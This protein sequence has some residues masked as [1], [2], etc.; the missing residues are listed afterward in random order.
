MYYNRSKAVVRNGRRH[1]ENIMAYERL[2]KGELPVLAVCYDFDK[3]LSPD[4]M[5]A[6]GYIQSVDCDV[7][8]FWRESNRLAEE[9]G[10]DMNLAYMYTMCKKAKGK[11]YPTLE[12]LREYGSRIRLYE[13]V[14][15]W[16]PR[17]NAYGRAHGV[18]VEHYIL[19]S[20]L[21]EMIEG[22][23]V[24]GEFKKIYASA[25]MF[26]DYGVPVWPAQAINYTNKTQFLFRIQKG[27]LDINDHKGVN[28]Y[29]PPEEIRVPFRN[30]V[31]L[32]DSETDVPCMKLVTSNGGHAVGVYDPVTRDT[33]LVRAM[34]RHRRIR[35]Y[36]PADYREGSAL[37]TLMKLIVD[38]TAANERLEEIHDDDVREAALRDDE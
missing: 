29:V 21:R 13:G 31:Y 4:N 6:Q 27:C 20:G 3:T 8:E 34:M 24:A 17:V 30:I 33:S 2:T 5:Q 32:G 11:F 7:D 36:A 23:S 35:Y 16:F 14:E 1:E 22:T 37:D 25:F 9:N 12:A 15:E 19:S 28:A 38:R 18:Q 10:M 26:D